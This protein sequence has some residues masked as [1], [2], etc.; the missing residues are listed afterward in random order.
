MTVLTARE[1]L[2][3][4][5]DLPNE[6]DD[7]WTTFQ[8]DL[9]EPGPI[10]PAFNFTRFLASSITFMA[11]LREVSVYFD[12]K[13]LALLTKDA[14]IPTQVT[15]PQGLRPTSTT[16]YMDIKGLKSTRRQIVNDKA[17]S[18][19][20]VVTLYSPPHHRRSLERCLQYR[21]GEV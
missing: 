5:G 12:D 8:M 16:G 20:T 21:N 7:T 9:R 17:R 19:L 2:A 1:V 3:R 13:R 14:G 10:P 18:V 15:M 4:R 6:T 11:H